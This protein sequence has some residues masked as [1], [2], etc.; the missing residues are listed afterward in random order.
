LAFCSFG[1]AKTNPV[2]S[3][4][5]ETKRPA[6]GGK[7]S[8]APPVGISDTDSEVATLLGGNCVGF[9]TE[10]PIIFIKFRKIYFNNEAVY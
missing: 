6:C 1:I 9:V 4:I 8:S 7:F 5:T 10:I 3:N 2:T